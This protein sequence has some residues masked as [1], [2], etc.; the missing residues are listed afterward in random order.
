MGQLVDVEVAKPSVDVTMSLRGSVIDFAIGAP[1]WFKGQPVFFYHPLV[2]RDSVGRIML[3][4]FCYDGKHPANAVVSAAHRFAR[5]M[6][7]PDPLAARR[8][9]EFAINCIH[10]LFKPASPDNLPT[11]GEWIAG[12]NYSGG[13][14]EY[15]TRLHKELITIN[16]N[17]TKNDSFIKAEIYKTHTKVPRAVNSYSDESKTILGGLF[18]CVDKATFKSRFFVKGSNPSTWPDRCAQ[19]FGEAAVISTDF[20]SFEAH[21]TGFFAE[22]VY[23]WF[24]YMTSELGL[25]N[26]IISLVKRLMLGRNL[27]K[28][29]GVN[30]EC[31]Q[32]LM[33]G[34]LWTSSANGVLNLLIH[35]YLAAHAVHGDGDLKLMAEWATQNAMGLVEGDD[36]LFMDYGQSDATA[37]SLGCILKVE[38]HERFDG[39]GFCGIICDRT[40]M[41]V[42]K[43]PI[44][45]LR[46]F[47]ALPAR[48]RFAHPRVH[49]Q[50]L[51][52]KAMSYYYG[53]RNAPIIGPVCKAILDATSHVTART[54]VLD[55][56]KVSNLEEAVV[57]QL[58]EREPEVELSSRLLVERIF[59]LDVDQQLELERQARVDTRRMNLLPFCTGPDADY[60]RKYVMPEIAWSGHNM[61]PSAIATTIFNECSTRSRAERRDIAD[62]APAQLTKTFGKV[63]RYYVPVRGYRPE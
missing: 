55:R 13:R 58:W 20:T 5:E 25:S 40:N 7:Q 63:D 46:N 48:Y 56:W 23:Y 4:P 12:S 37:L 39:A 22:V 24:C 2:P 47:F 17:T 36:G 16:N 1:K 10:M 61:M 29:P 21:H 6:P 49:D 19:L 42:V 18:H 43:D 9:T 53:F 44:K 35:L 11:F 15:L 31:N 51:R 38:R 3:A 57:S 62:S 8:F 28:F 41:Q 26:D 54:D 34:A 59:G 32:R 52:A 27:I 14:K 33:S 60:V 30:V 45:F 50:L